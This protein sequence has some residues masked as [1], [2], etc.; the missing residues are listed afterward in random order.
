MDYEVARLLD[1]NLISLIVISKLC[2][3]HQN[4]DASS[5]QA[6]LSDEINNSQI[7]EILRVRSSIEIV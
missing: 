4:A 6:R 7:L 3:E 5:S 2:T 1:A